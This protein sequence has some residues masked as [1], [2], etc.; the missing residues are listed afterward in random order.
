MGMYML[1]RL[2]NNHTLTKQPRWYHN[3]DCFIQY[4]QVSTFI[5]NMLS[6]FIHE[7]IIH[8]CNNTNEEHLFQILN[9]DLKPCI[10]SILNYTIPTPIILPYW[11]IDG[12]AW[13]IQLHA[14][15]QTKHRIQLFHKHNNINFL[16][17]KIIDIDGDHF[18]CRKY[19][20]I[21]MHNHICNT[22]WFITSTTEINA[23]STQ[24]RIYTGWAKLTTIISI[25]KTW[26]HHTIHK[27]LDPLANK[28]NFRPPIIVI[29]CTLPPSR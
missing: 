7:L 27:H 17:N 23:N 15:F 22:H 13:Y 14:I 16:P 25:N 5:D 18:S 12:N 2:W 26:R 11:Q 3:N 4:H 19:S 29:D 1:S 24:R 9:Q 20:N 6:H 10:P 8:E 21:Q 28:I